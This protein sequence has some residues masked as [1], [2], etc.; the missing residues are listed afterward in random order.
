LAEKP[1]QQVLSAYEA[2]AEQTSLLLGQHKDL[3]GRFGEPFK[4]TPSLTGRTIGFHRR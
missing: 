3:T 4:H 2:V 1:E